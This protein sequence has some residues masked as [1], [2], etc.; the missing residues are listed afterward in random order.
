MLTR[1]A[2]D[3]LV[4]HDIIPANVIEDQDEEENV[5]DEVT[6]TKVRRSARIRHLEAV[7][8]EDGGQAPAVGDDNGFGNEAETGGDPGEDG[9]DKEESE[10]EKESGDEYREDD[11]DDDDDD[12]SPLTRPSR[13][14][15]KKELAA[16]KDCAGFIKHVPASASPKKEQSSGSGEA[17]KTQAEPQT[18]S[19]STN[20]EFSTQSEAK[21]SLPTTVK[22]EPGLHEDAPKPKIPEVSVKREQSDSDSDDDEFNAEERAEFLRL[23]VSFGMSEGLTNRSNSIH[24]KRIRISNSRSTNGEKSK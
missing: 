19:P 13:S 24:S 7:R 9:G 16:L 14:A 3:L 10:G 18:T 22:K 20:K 5:N 21:P 17:T 23:Q 6:I 12:F 4:A 8:E 11:D 15:A 1:L 2:I